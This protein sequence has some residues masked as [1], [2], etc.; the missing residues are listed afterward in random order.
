MRIQ[1]VGL[2]LACLLLPSPLVVGS[3]PETNSSETYAVYSAILS[4]PPLSHEDRSAKYAITDTTATA[5]FFGDGL[6]IPQNYKPES[7]AQIKSEYEKR[8]NIP[9]PLKRA[10]TL[11]KPYIFLTFQQTLQ[12]HYHAY[13]GVDDVLTLSDVYFDRSKTLAIVYVWAF[14]G[15]ICALGGW[16]ILEKAPNGHWHEI[17]QGTCGSAMS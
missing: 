16:H 1:C 9:V 17:F 14:C 15:P 7:F 11:R 2:A 13:K 5:E 10:F 4:P 3:S 12:F 8:K 6:C